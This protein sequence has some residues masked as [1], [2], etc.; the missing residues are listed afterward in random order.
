[1][2]DAAAGFALLTETL[3][4]P[5]AW[6]YDDYGGFASGRV[7][8][9]NLNVELVAANAHV[10]AF[11]PSTPARVRESPSSFITARVL[12]VNGS[13][14][15]MTCGPGF[16]TCTDTATLYAAE[17]PYFTPGRSCAPS[18]SPAAATPSISRRIRVTTARL[19][20]TG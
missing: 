19:S 13:R 4:L 14:D 12:I 8:F 3:G 15:R 20:S 1:M 10:P 18:C 6:K 5:I 7:N 11:D 16:G 2:T 17:R 9:G